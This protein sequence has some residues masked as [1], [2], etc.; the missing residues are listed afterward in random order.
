MAIIRCS[1]C[2]V[3]TNPK[4]AVGD[5]GTSPLQVSLAQVKNRCF[6]A[7]LAQANSLKGCWVIS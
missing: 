1:M 3:N 5:R 4:P 7:P 2:T 6:A